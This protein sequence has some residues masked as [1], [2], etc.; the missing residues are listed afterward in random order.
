M[1]R[2]LSDEDVEAIAQRVVA[3][4]IG[5]RGAINPGAI[6]KISE[7]AP[8]VSMH[9]ETMRQKLRLGVIG[10]SR[11]SGDWRIKG[12]ELLKMA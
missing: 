4:S 8:L 2:V 10:G 6:Y 7:A 1:S 3:L 12:S 5:A 9:P 11:R